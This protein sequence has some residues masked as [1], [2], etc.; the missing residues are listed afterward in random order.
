MNLQ[1]VDITGPGHQ[2]AGHLRA[3]CHGGND[4]GGGG[5]LGHQFL[6]AP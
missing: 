2:T 1:A 5:I 3:L 6:G 4:M